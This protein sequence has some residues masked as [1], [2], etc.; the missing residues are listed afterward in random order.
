MKARFAMKCERC[1]ELIH[2]G[3]SCV[4]LHGRIWCLDCAVAYIRDRKRSRVLA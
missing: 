2:T 3:G 4:R 1:K